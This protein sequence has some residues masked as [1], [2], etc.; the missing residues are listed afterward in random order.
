MDDTLSFSQPDAQS[1]TQL[2]FQ[3]MRVRKKKNTKIYCSTDS[4]DDLGY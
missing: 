3:G 2:Y 1:S 4:L